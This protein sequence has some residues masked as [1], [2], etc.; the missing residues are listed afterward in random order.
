MLSRWRSSTA[1][2]PR[3]CACSTPPGIPVVVPGERFTTELHAVVDYLQLFEAWD[4]RF[5]GFETEMQ[6]VT[7]HQTD[8][9]VWY[10]VPCVREAAS[11]TDAVTAAS[12]PPTHNPGQVA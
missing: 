9:R 5:P 3:F 1:G 7:R 10:S 11:P 2:S 6:G 12:G 4:A 8:G